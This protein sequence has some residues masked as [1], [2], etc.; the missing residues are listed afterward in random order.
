MTKALFAVVLVGLANSCA[1][2]RAVR[3]PDGSPYTLEV[4]FDR[5]ALKGA[6]RV[7]EVAEF[8]EPN[9]R[10]L[11]ENA[12]YVVVRSSNP[13]DFV[14]GPGRFLLIIRV[15][16]YYPG[17]KKVGLDTQHLMYS[18]PG[19]LMLQSVGSVSGAREWSSAARK[20]NQQITREVTSAL[21]R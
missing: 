16:A 3:S 10:G 7:A 1:S 14:P 6:D 5:N 19:Q 9:L 21:S 2:E 12:G 17:T 20:I 11:L 18:G 13:E 8:M 4:F 15:V